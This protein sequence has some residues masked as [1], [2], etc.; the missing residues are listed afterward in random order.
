[1]SSN[2]K[3]KYSIIARII[4]IVLFVLFTGYGIVQLFYQK[5]SFTP[6]RIY[7]ALIISIL[8]AFISSS[9][10]LLFNIVGK[11]GKIDSLS[12]NINYINDSLVNHESS[13]INKTDNLINHISILAQK[14][15]LKNIKID[16]FQKWKLA[17][18]KKYIE[19]LITIT[20]ETK[21]KFN[22]MF[23]G[24][25]IL[26]SDIFK[27]YYLEILKS[28]NVTYYYSSAI[29]NDDKYFLKNN[30]EDLKDEYTIIADS[31]TKVELLFILNDGKIYDSSLKQALIESYKELEKKVGGNPNISLFLGFTSNFNGHKKELWK[32]DFGIAGDIACAEM[33]TE[34]DKERY[35]LYFT[36]EK[37]KD[38]SEIYKF[39][40]DTI[41]KKM[42]D[43]LAKLNS[44]NV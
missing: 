30:I 35:T 18:R 29:V 33:S 32:K 15:D 13:L 27:G 16:E 38:L 5:I 41:V 6:E 20:P 1:M 14:I 9:V 11:L 22:S 36:P 24:E 25:F 31:G 42:T 4:S 37:H 21:N 17:V 19:H 26:S 7:E 43:N 2:K 3:D 40:K 10:P 34:T 23:S 28:K 44:L 8:I 12:N 39:Q